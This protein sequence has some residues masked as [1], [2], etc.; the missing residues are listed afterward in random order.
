[1]KLNEPITWTPNIDRE[2][3]VLGA[4]MNGTTKTWNLS[5]EALEDCPADKNVQR[6]I[7]KSL[8]V[9]FVP[10]AEGQNRVQTAALTIAAS[11]SLA[12]SNDAE[13]RKFAQL[14][15]EEARKSIPEDGR[16]H[17][18]VGVVVVKDGSILASAHRGEIP[19]CH[20]EFIALEKK[21]ENVS[22]SGSTVYTTLEPCTSRNHPKIPRAD[23]LADRKVARV[24]IG[25][26][27][28]DDRISGRG[29]RRLRKAGITTVLF[30]EDL[31]AE[32]EELNRDFVRDRESGDSKTRERGRVHFVSDAYNNGWAVQ[33]DKQME[34][35]LGGTFTYDGPGTL[36]VLKA[37]LEDTEPTTDMM[38]QVVNASGF[39]KTVPHLE[40]QSRT[41]L[42]AF[43]DLRLTPVR[44]NR[45]EVLSSQVVFRDAYNQDYPFEVSLPYIGQR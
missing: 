3:Y 41:P 45:G 16:V 35:R 23:R 24:V 34:V 26:L 10:D 7:E 11:D 30:P 18:R 1:M 27:D 32:V 19:Q 4:K 9:Y 12:S 5:Y 2:I 17:P 37:F 36:T 25:M 43:I 20:A 21:L 13:D 22:L 15:V 28:P 29:Q 44:G 38:I 40:L 6:E 14:A 31:M 33:F 42:R 39:P 8:R